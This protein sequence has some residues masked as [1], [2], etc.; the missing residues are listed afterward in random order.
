MSTGTIHHNDYRGSVTSLA[1]ALVNDTEKTRDELIS[2]ALFHFWADEVTTQSLVFSALGLNDVRVR[3]TIVWYTQAL[4]PTEAARAVEML[5][6]AAD[7]VLTLDKEWSFNP[8]ANSVPAYTVAGMVAILA[9]DPITARWCADIALGLQPSYSLAILLDTSL[10]AG[11]TADCLRSD[12]LE[13]DFKA[14]RHGY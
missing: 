14:C 5:I 6:K 9:N 11:V 3:D 2:L 8:G 1:E 4:D 13:L 7:L 12:I 10:K